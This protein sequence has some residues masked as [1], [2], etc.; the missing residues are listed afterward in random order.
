[1]GKIEDNILNR[2]FNCNS[3]NQKWVTDITYLKYDNG[4]KIMYLSAIK[5]LYNREIIAYKISDSLD[6]SFVEQTLGEAF[7]NACI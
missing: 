4:R 3:P 2:E 1:M 6:I 7:K 5:D